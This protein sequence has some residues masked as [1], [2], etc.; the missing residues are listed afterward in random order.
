MRKGNREKVFQTLAI[1]RNVDDAFVYK[2]QHFDD[3]TWQQLCH[4][5]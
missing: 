5:T 3:L 2:N 4:L 1:K